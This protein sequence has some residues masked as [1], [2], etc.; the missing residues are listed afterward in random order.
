MADFAGDWPTREILEDISAKALEKIGY[1][2]EANAMKSNRDGEE[3]EIDVWA[4]TPDKAF[5]VYVSCKNWANGIG[6]P[7]IDSET[8]RI[9]N[10]LD[11]PH[12][13]VIVTKEF[14]GKAKSLAEKNG[15]IPIEVGE[16]ATEENADKIREIIEEEFKRN[17]NYPNSGYF[18]QL[19]LDKPEK[20]AT[21]WGHRLNQNFEEVDK[22][23]S[24]IGSN[25]GVSE[26][27]NYQKP[28]IRER[29]WHISLNS[30]FKQIE[31]DMKL[32]AEKVDVEGV[33]G[34]DQPD[35]GTLNWHSNLNRN[36]S[37]IEDDVEKI[38]NNI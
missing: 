35:S 8:G 26:V 31:T 20:G 11:Q 10:L 3:I 14:N 18:S 34:Y 12:L 21:N 7:K 17:L 33:G 28:N 2:V 1:E 38:S 13:K 9:S 37:K 5:S 16:K 25:L 24:N 19:K 4:N 15:F 23:V 36:F 27:G 32:L 29:N 30:T 22:Y 6:R